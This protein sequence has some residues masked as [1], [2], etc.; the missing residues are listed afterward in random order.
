MI[1]L[2]SHF[3]FLFTLAST[4]MRSEREVLAYTAISL[5]ADLGGALSLFVGVSAL[6]L[7]DC[8]SCLV[9]TYKDYYKIAK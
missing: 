6:S 8:F 5:I 3:V 7:W 4:Q 9:T 1:F 2:F